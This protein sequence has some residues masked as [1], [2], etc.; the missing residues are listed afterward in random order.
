MYFNHQ[1]C[2]WSLY[3]MRKILSRGWYVGKSE[4]KLTWPRC[5]ARTKH[6]PLSERIRRR[7]TTAPGAATWGTALPLVRIVSAEA[8]YWAG[9]GHLLG[10]GVLGPA[11][12]QADVV[13]RG[14]A[15]VAAGLPQAGQCWHQQCEQGPPV[16]AVIGGFILCANLSRHCIKPYNWSLIH[17]ITPAK[18]VKQQHISSSR[19]A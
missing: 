12:D 7:V 14:E 8:R 19:S 11:G 5:P 4:S 3:S 2:I 15:R 16:T 18:I 17:V 9:I 13:D 1:A 10:V 6:D